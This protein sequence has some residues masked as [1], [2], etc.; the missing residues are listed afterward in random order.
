MREITK[1]RGSPWKFQA[2]KD[3]VRASLNK[4]CGTAYMDC[5]KKM[6]ILESLHKTAVFLFLVCLFCNE[7]W[8]GTMVGHLKL[9]QK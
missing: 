9:T 1:V 5:I 2:K 4:Y 6:A 8:Y 3:V 7:V